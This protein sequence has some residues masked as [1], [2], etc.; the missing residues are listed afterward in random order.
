[1]TTPI[2]APTDVA[3]AEHQAAA[4]P[5]E[6]L[7]WLR[8]GNQRFA[9][10]SMAQRD[11][12]AHAGATAGGQ[13]PLASVLGCIDSRVPVETVLDMGI[14]DVF[15]ARTAG[16]VADDVVI[17]S[18]EFAT[19]IAGSKVVVV[20]GHEACG[21]VKGACD[22]AELGFLTGLLAKITPAVEQVAGSTAPGSG[23]AE[24]VAKIVEQN[25]R[26]VVAELTGRSDVLAG[27]VEQGD[28]LV[29]GAVYD[30][31]TGVIRWLD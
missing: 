18:L 16:N 14:G 17:G 20:L 2:H 6:V 31:A 13:H 7:A 21:A 29:V 23:D 11:L 24:L 3:T 25:V 8:A 9:T 4:T 28:L 27:L 22:G 30:L 1:M 15:T 19:A 5:A 10:A 26:N 12:L